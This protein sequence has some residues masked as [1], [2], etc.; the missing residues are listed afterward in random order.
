MASF[1][2]QNRYDVESIVTETG[3]RFQFIRDPNHKIIRSIL[4]R[5]PNIV[6]LFETGQPLK[7]N[8]ADCFPFDAGLYFNGAADVL[9]WG[10]TNK[11]PFANC[12]CETAMRWNVFFASKTCTR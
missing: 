3:L 6:Y 10:G 9:H 7:V 1:T 2:V 5:D 11:A 4:S 12:S 8:T